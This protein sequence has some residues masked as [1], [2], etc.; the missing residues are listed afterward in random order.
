MKDGF[1]RTQGDQRHFCH[2]AACKLDKLDKQGMRG[3]M[4]EEGENHNKEK[5]VQVERGVHLD[6]QSVMVRG[7]GASAGEN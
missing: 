3:G 5:K 4:G 7:R 1:W 2:G 6:W